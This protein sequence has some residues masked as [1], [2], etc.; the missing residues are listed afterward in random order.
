M[1]KHE[2]GNFLDLIFHRREELKWEQNEQKNIT[3]FI[4]NRG[5]FNRIAQKCFKR[6]K[7]SQIHLDEMGSFVWP[8][9]DGEHTVYHI[10]TEVSAYFG[11]KAEPLYDRLVKYMQILE[12]QGFIFF[13]HQNR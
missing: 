5:I 3:L 7:V 6:P 4:E 10:A 1:K 2:D 12:K 13:D 9:I 8:L 11:E